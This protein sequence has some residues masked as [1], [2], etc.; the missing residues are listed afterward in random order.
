MSARAWAH[1]S[2]R[3]A[4]RPAVAQTVQIEM[5][6]LARAL[7]CGRRLIERSASAHFNGIIVRR[8]IWAQGPR[9]DCKLSFLLSLPL[10]PLLPGLSQRPALWSAEGLCLVPAF[11]RP[12]TLGSTAHMDERAARSAA[13]ELQ[14]N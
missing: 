12:L 7:R 5:H 3:K 8:I 9:T 13:T 14:R 4:Q 2:S 6:A 1:W 11:Q 10:F